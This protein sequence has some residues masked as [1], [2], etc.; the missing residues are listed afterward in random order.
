MFFIDCAPDEFLVNT[1]SMSDKG[2]TINQHAVAKL[3]GVSHATVSLVF[4][5]HP[6]ISEP[7]RKKV[8]EAAKKLN[9]VPDRNFAARKLAFYRLG[10]KL[11][12]KIIGIPWALSG[13]WS[14][15]ESFH[16]TIFD[17][18]V[19]ACWDSDRMLVM[20]DMNC[21]EE[22]IKSKLVHLDGLV[23]PTAMLKFIT[24]AKELN[25]PTVS[26][27]GGYEQ[28]IDVRAD[29]AQ[30]THTIVNF[31]YEK[32]YRKLAYVGPYIESIFAFKRWEGFLKGV[33][34]HVLTMDPRWAV[35]DYSLWDYEKQ[36]YESFKM[37]WNLDNLP[38]AVV[39]YNDKMALG[40]LQAAREL[41]VNI[42]G[43][44]AIVGIDG[45][46]EGQSSNPP[47]TTYKLDL[48]NAGQIALEALDMIDTPGDV[49]GMTRYLTGS[50]IAGGTTR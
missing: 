46:P 36:G 1:A 44:V 15:Q 30:M 20:I 24:A 11:K 31:L 7:T 27:F 47:L 25:L 45:I 37:L 16:R 5:G 2:N 10:K 48:E 38:E 50:M 22:T 17:S 9:Y 42:P 28:I 40:A 21:A 14:H 49:V 33:R 13:G 4:S 3:A 41:G 12:S 35:H 32:G 18:V 29:D 43:K 39:F 23:I 34:E 8:L 6:R 19:K 26:I